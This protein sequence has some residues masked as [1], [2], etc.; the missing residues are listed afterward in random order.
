MFSS[1][2]FNIS[3]SQL[4]YIFVNKMTIWVVKKELVE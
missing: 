1:L 4:D 2:Y 3:I